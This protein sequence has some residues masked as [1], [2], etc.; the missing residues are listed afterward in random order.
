[1]ESKLKNCKFSGI[2]RQ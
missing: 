1:V 2:V